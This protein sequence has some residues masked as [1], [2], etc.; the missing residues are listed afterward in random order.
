MQVGMNPAL[1]DEQ[2]NE[3]KS[4]PKERHDGTAHKDFLPVVILSVAKDP[5]GFTPKAKI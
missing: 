4:D 1:H 3:G 5:N 2:D